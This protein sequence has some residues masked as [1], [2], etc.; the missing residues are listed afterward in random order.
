MPDGPEFTRP[1]VA[2]TTA[3]ARPDAGT[4][5]P[6][7]RSLASRSNRPWV[8]ALIAALAALAFALARWQIWAQGSIG[9]FILVGRHFSTPAQLAPG[10]PVA[11]TYGYDGQFFYRLAVNPLNFSPTAYGI[12]MDRPY[13]FMRIGYPALTW[14]FSLGQ[15]FLVPVMLVVVN[16]AAIGALGY[17][18]ARFAVAG[19]RHALAGLLLPGYFGLITSLSRDTA[20]PLAAVCLLAGLLAIR[21]RRPVLAAALLAYGALTRETVMVAVAALAIM[22]AVGVMRRRRSPR[23]GRDDLTWAV[24]TVVFVAWQV[25]VKA[26]TGSVPLL[27]DGGRN[28]GAPFIA[29]LQAL[30]NN[31]HHVNLHEFDQY[32]LW[33]L[34]LAILVLFALG[35]LLCLRSTNA[36]VHERLAF[37][38]Y[39][40]EICV[41]TPSTWGSLDADMRSFVE[42]YLLAVIILLGV[43]RR[44][45]GA[46]LLPSLAA[47]T[48]PALIVVTQ[49]RLV[50]SLRLRL[51]ARLDVNGAARPRRHLGR[52]CG[53]GERKGRH[54]GSESVQPTDRTL[55]SLTRLAAA[56]GVVQVRVPGKPADKAVDPSEDDLPAPQV[57]DSLDPQPLSLDRGQQRR[58]AQVDQVA[59]QVE[60]QPAIAEEAGLEAGRIGHGDDQRPA[61]R[62]QRCRVAQRLGRLA[63]MLERMPEDDRRPVPVHL[64]DL[65]AADV[66]P[67]C[68]RLEA[69]GFAPVADK[70]LDE[71]PVAGSHVENRA[72]RQD[73]VQAIGKR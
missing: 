49:R 65:G 15:H 62:Q 3:S 54:G 11:P 45:F 68:V 46:W 53:Q 44:T 59:G 71:G 37:V 56:D 52:G 29:P 21:T 22:R 61:R 55:G 43:P 69:D 2:P 12:R 48:V 51:P 24:P 57:A 39:L 58:R 47:L 23:P 42:V 41:V 25:I 13:R 34:Q 67:G 17:L 6:P 66:R 35:A 72:G 26:A 5:A 50:G 36:P 14:L 20:E 63:E 70:G 4:D 64:F 16:I 18:G 7:S 8:A 31:L 30:K 60:G 32:D 73:P 40:V 28:A 1:A 38:L 10:I 19:G 33:F 9:R 27:A